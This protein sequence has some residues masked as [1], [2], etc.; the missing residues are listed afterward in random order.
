[1]YK[2]DHDGIAF[3]SESPLKSKHKTRL[4]AAEAFAG[5][6]EPFYSTSYFLLF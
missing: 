4:P 5:S 1:M 6:E 2:Q 3:K